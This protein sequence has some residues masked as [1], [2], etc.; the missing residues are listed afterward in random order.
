MSTYNPLNVDAYTAQLEEA[1]NAYDGALLAVAVT[2]TDTTAGNLYRQ[3]RDE[4]A[5]ARGSAIR[6]SLLRARASRGDT[7]AKGDQDS[8]D[9]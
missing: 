8:E 5:V 7:D 9:R 1:L 6:N 4:H 3:L 2:S